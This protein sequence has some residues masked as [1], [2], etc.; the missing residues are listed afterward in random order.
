VTK[1]RQT[2]GALSKCE[3]ERGDGTEYRTQLQDFE[4]L[5]GGAECEATLTEAVFEGQL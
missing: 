2:S 3:V 1:A 5:I 4:R